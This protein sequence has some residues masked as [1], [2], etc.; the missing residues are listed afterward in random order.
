[1]AARAKPLYEAEAKARQGS[2]TGLDTKLRGSSGKSL[3]HATKLFDPALEKFSKFHGA[4]HRHGSLK[5]AAGE[6]KI[7]LRGTGNGARTREVS[8]SKSC[9]ATAGKRFSIDRQLGPLFTLNAVLDFPGQG[10]ARRPA[11]SYTP[12]VPRTLIN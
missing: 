2:R 3:D 12:A 5:A 4:S 6:R 7:F 10:E 11:R 1:M 8:I 9:R